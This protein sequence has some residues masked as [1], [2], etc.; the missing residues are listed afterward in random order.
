[1]KST[2][3]SRSTSPIRIS[4]STGTST[5]RWV[6][7]SISSLTT[8][9]QRWPAM[10]INFCATPSH[11]RTPSC[12]S[13]ERQGSSHSNIIDINMIRYVNRLIKIIICKT[14]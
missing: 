2:A 7:G 1:M 9:G 13:C 4:T 3:S 10:A 14:L 12:C 11:P 8:T 6:C 5:P